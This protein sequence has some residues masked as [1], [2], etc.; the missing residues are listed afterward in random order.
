VT[1]SGTNAA[2][3]ED[4]QNNVAP[5]VG[6]AW[7]LPHTDRFVLRGGY[8]TYFTRTTGQPFLQ[9]LGAP[10]YGLIRTEL[11]QPFSSP[12][13]AAP[14]TFP[15]FPA[16]SPATSLTPVTFSPTFR[17]PIVQEY[18]LNLQTQLAHNLVLEVGYEGTRGTHLLQFRDF[19]QA[20]SASSA[21]P[22]RG[23]TSNTLANLP[24]RVPYEGFSPTSSYIIE[25]EGTSWYNGLDVSLNKRFSKGLQLLA[26]YTWARSLTADDQYSTSSNGGVLVGNQN[27]AAARYGP[28]GFIRPQRLVVSFVY[29]FPSP[30]GASLLETRT[31]GGWSVAGVATFQAGHYLTLTD[32]NA[33]NAFGIAAPGGDLVELAA[34][35]TTGRVATPGSANSRLN[36][37]LNASCLTGP[38]V[39]TADGGTD[40]GD[41][42]VGVVRGPDQRNFDLAI[43]KKTP[44]STSHEAL[45]LEFR[46]EFFNAFN[47]SQFA[48]PANLDAGTVV[49]PAFVPS[50]SFGVITSTSVS[51]R[52][53]QLALKLNF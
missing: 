53:V 16:Y 40:F 44:L 20:L 19:N 17:P 3:N 51:P 41:L 11:F 23:E 4:G 5:R 7:Q 18:S 45:N 25:S 9:L 31:L 33:T 28:D 50:P 27:N 8:G 1:R 15:Y 36:N 37:F 29:D 52:V 49:G 46:A 34:G 6:F 39:I 32:T 10:P 35:C 43:V 22:I 48:D 12:F 13:P 26:S 47:T 24:L 14:A 21:N 2:I 30:T 42:A 38:P